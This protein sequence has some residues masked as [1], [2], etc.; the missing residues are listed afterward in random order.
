MIIKTVGISRTRLFR[1][2]MVTLFTED[3]DIE[4]C[5]VMHGSIDFCKVCAADPP[6]AVFWHDEGPDYDTLL[7]IN[8]VMAAFPDVKLV[9]MVSY[10]DDKIV[11]PL[12]AAG[13]HAC[14]GPKDGLKEVGAAVRLVVGGEKYVSPCVLELA[15]RSTTNRMENSG[16]EEPL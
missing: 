9:A 1:D 2:L 6:D 4:L 16:R 14:L 7:G 11:M 15:D 12:L 3:D 5:G 13:V 10:G 8:E